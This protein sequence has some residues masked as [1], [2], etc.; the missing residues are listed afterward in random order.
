MTLF[1]KMGCEEPSSLP[2]LQDFLKSDLKKVD[3]VIEEQLSSSVPLVPQLGR[4]LIQ[5]GGKR[6]RPLLTLASNR[7]FEDKSPSIFLLAAAVEF[8]HTATL[9]HDDVVDNSKTRRGQETANEVWGNQASVLVG[10]FLFAKSFQLMVETQSFEVLSTLSQASAKIAEG[11]VLQLSVCHDFALNLDDLL[12]VISAKTA[13]LFGAACKV[14]AIMA[15]QD[16]SVIQALYHYGHNLGMA[17]QIIDDI[18]DYT[19][20]NNS[21]GKTVGDDFREGKITL[22]VFLSYQQCVEEGDDQGRSFWQKA[23]SE[24]ESGS[25]DLEEAQ[26]LLTKSGS[27]TAALTMAQNYGRSAQ[28]QLKLLPTHPIR[29]YFHGLV[30]ELLIRKS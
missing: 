21:L 2:L 9:L 27:I 30:D 1:A 28:E 25:A 24:N 17:F 7:L 19:S 20:N 23:F 8:I 12:T 14:G 26:D 6:L 4:H 15:N 16:Q 18:L 29:E 10:D 3:Q 22:P 11:E 5:A 13:E